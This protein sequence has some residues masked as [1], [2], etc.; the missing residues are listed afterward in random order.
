MTTTPVL[1]PILALALFL[2][3]GCSSLNPFASDTPKPAPLAGFKPEADL[4]KAWSASVGEADGYVFQPAIVG[5]SVY[6]AGAKG[7]VA[8]FEG[9]QGG[10]AAWRVDVG[11]RLAAGVG[12]DGDLAVVVS[13]TGQVIALDAQTGAERWRAN[14]GVEVLAPPAIGSGVVVLRA[15]DHRLIAL[16]ASNG[17]RRW[18]YQRSTPP[19]GLRGHAGVLIESNVVLAG[20]PGG[21]LVA[22]N[23]DNGGGVWE[24]NVATPR[25]STELERVTDVAG[26]PVIG[27]REI[28]AVTYQGRAAC[29]DATNGNALWARDFSSHSG[30]DR[31]SRF[32][33]ITD[34]RDSIQ[35]LDAYSGTTVWR[36]DDLARRGVSRPLIVGDYV[37]AGDVEG[38]VHVLARE[39]GHF[40]ARARADSSAIGADPR[41]HGN[42]F[43]VQTRDGDVVAYELQPLTP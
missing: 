11:T 20:L 25:G 3:S 30:M 22:V 39:N 34:E 9:G 38:Y 16:E 24:L 4:R 18:L 29:F 43:V 10:R 19:L 17:Q 41:L 23:L 37:V 2:F 14:L 28:C 31:D 21:K 27:R 40:V 36:Q 32:V 1:A 8:R 12:S 15:S 5:E 33:V 13:E 42:G 7:R 26:T 35:A 6:A